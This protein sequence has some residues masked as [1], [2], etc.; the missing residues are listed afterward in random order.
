MFLV[1]VHGSG[2][3]SGICFKKS[4]G[5]CSD[6]GEVKGSWNG[7]GKGSIYKLSRSSLFLST[8]AVFIYNGSR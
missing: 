7:L 8:Q 1:K 4:M 5:K 6:N 2:Y 3:G